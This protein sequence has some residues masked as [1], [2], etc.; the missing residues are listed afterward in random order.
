MIR[1][2]NFAARTR[3][4]VGRRGCA[5]LVFSFIDAVVGGSLLDPQIRAQTRALPAYRALLDVAPL[6]VWAFVWLAVAAACA[7]QAWMRWDAFAFAA[8]T[9]VKVVWAAGLTVAW[10]VYDAPRGWLSASLWGVLAMLVLVINGW[11][12]PVP[13]VRE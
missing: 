10:I 12:E 6:T 11:P 3:A 2:S 9:A 13:E 1:L 8:A 5:L 7:V 4:R